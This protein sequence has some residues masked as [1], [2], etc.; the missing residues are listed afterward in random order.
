MRRRNKPTV[1]RKRG[2]KLI[3]HGFRLTEAD[4]ANLEEIRDA[5]EGKYPFTVSTSI[6]VGVALQALV[7]ETRSGKIRST[8]DLYI[9]TRNIGKLA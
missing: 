5:Y 9:S 4:T 3:N 8:P 1:Y 2:Q 7:E 6:I